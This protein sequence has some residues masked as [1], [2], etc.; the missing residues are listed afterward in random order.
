MDIVHRI[1]AAA[2]KLIYVFKFYPGKTTPDTDKAVKVSATA[3][4]K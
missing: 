2:I 3:V 1:V 4:V